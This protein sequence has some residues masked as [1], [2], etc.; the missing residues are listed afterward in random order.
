MLYPPPLP[1]LG[2]DP[3]AWVARVQ[4]AAALTIGHLDQGWQGSVRQRA[5]YS[6]ALGPVDWTVDAALVVLGWLA[7]ND[8][9]IRP[10]VLSLFA[11]LETQI[12]KEGYTCFEY[13]LVCSWLAMGGHDGATEERLAAWK[14]RIEEARRAAAD[15]DAPKEGKELDAKHGGLTLERYAE[16]SVRRDAILEKHGGGVAKGTA[17]MAGRGAYPELAE[18]CREYGLDPNLAADQASAAAGR[19]PEW[20]R[21]INARPRVQERFF[22][23]QNDARLKLQGIAFNSHEGRVAEMIR[24]GGFDAESARVNAEVA[25]KKMASGDE[26]E[27]DPV[28]FPGQKLERLSH[29]VALMKGMQSGDMMGALARAGLDMGSYGTAAQAWGIKLASDPLLTAKFSKMMAG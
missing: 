6:L 2:I 18:L 24:S 10:D 27:P 16:L 11:Y 1:D 21:L 14:K 4:I 13:P 19:I 29:Y 15:D 23:M 17:G 12:P 20:D 7:H 26:G 28:V 9:Q 3:L 5:L 8:P 22:A 25:A